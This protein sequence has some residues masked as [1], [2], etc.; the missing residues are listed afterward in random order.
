MAQHPGFRSFTNPQTKQR[1]FVYSTNPEIDTGFGDA[2]Q[3]FTQGEETPGF[4]VLGVDKPQPEEPTGFERFRSAAIQGLGGQGSLGEF[5]R[6]AAEVVI[7]ETPEGLAAEGALIGASLIPGAQAGTIPAL[8]A[9]IMSRL[10]GPGTRLAARV[11][12]PPAAAITTAEALDRP[13]GPALVTGLMSSLTETFGPLFRVG[14]G[15]VQKFTTKSKIIKTGVE[16][17]IKMGPAVVKDVNAFKQ[18]LKGGRSDLIDL[19]NPNKGLKVLKEQFQ[20]TDDAIIKAFKGEKITFTRPVGTATGSFSQSAKDTLALLKT[21]KAVAR[22]APKD[23]DGF[24]LREQVRKFEGEVRGALDSKPGLLKKYDNAVAD[25]DKGL[26]ILDIF[27]ESGA[28]IPSAQGAFLQQGVLA[29][30]LNKNIKRFPPEK[31]P[32]IWSAATRGR[33]VGFT[34][35]SE[36]IAVRLFPGK[37]AATIRAGTAVEKAGQDI[38]RFGVPGRA[39]LPVSAA[40]IRVGE[41]GPT[42][43][44][45][46]EIRAAT[47]LADSPFEVN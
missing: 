33:G 7:P 26:D 38:A 1:A 12:G 4:I 28:V 40:A 3:K 2:L 35:I 44:R 23:A 34:D 27:E 45:R 36:E 42:K 18:I 31:F 25:F 24:A 16:D 14:K 43:K 13:K 21:Q 29:D 11:L 46:K 17:S 30:F 32:S 15:A 9:R 6:K 39:Q 37:G 47:K 5:A 20:A 19:L 8:S 10:T 41:Q 22:K